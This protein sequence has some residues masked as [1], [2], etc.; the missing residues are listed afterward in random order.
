[1]VLGPAGAAARQRE[2]AAGRQHAVRLGDRG[3]RVVEHVDDERRGDKL[4]LAATRCAHYQ[5]TAVRPV[6]PLP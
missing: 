4:L 5:F 6:A 1:M 2:P 3:G